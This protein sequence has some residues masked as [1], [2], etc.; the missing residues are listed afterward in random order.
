MAMWNG[1][2][3]EDFI[4]GYR[5]RG[6]RPKNMGQGIYWV[7][8]HLADSRAEERRIIA[9]QRRIDSK[10]ESVRKFNE[11][12]R[13]ILQNHSRYYEK[14]IGIELTISM[15]KFDIINKKAE[16]YNDV[17]KYIG[18]N[19]ENATM[20]DLSKMATAARSNMMSLAKALGHEASYDA[21]TKVATIEGVDYDFS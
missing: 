7:Q 2:P 20:G 16:I 9:E 3:L 12:W 21:A 13:R 15:S 11:K 19:I 5:L 10:N 4:M 6:G 1:H 8:R 18:A 17:R 14:V